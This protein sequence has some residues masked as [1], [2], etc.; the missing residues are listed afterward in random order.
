[1]P[2]LQKRKGKSPGPEALRGSGQANGTKSEARCEQRSE[3]SVYSNALCGVR[4]C[5]IGRRG[6]LLGGDAGD[7]FGVEPEVRAWRRL[8]VVDINE[9]RLGVL[10]GGVESEML[11][12]YIVI[13]EPWLIAIFS[14]ARV[15]ILHGGL[16]G[17]GCDRAS[18]S[19]SFSGSFFQ[20]SWSV[21]TPRRLISRRG[22]HETNGAGRRT[23]TSAPASASVS[24]SRLCAPQLLARKRGRNSEGLSSR[25]SGRRDRAV[26]R[27]P[28]Q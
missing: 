21:A 11:R 22:K 10:R 3:G 13:K 19:A 27:G 1:M 16:L 7:S 5:W 12:A 4:L 23:A 18:F 6:L 24:S 17:A 20:G 9:H 14:G 25:R 26:E 28:F 8:G 15:H 2:A